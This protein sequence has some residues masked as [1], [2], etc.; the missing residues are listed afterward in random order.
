MDESTKAFPAPM[1]NP[2][3]PGNSDLKEVDPELERDYR[4]LAQWLLDVHRELHRRRSDP[5]RDVQFDRSAQT[6]TI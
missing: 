4:L 6:P 5:A 2:T 3:N 1:P